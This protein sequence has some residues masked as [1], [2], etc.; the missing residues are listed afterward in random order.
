[1][2]NG[3]GTP[4]HITLLVD[5]KPVGEG[6]LSVTIPIQIGLTASVSVGANPGSPTLPDYQPPYK[7]TGEVHKAFVDVTGKPVE[8]YEAKMRMYLARQ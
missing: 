3:K 8:N 5:G 2:A 4:A 7:F 1:M 6:D